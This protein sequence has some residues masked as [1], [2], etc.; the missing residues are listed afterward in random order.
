MISFHQGYDSDI[1]LYNMMQD[2]RPKLITPS[3][4]KSNGSKQRR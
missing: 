3:P 4:S 1:S 2:L